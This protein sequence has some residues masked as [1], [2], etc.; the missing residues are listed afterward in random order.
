MVWYNKTFSLRYVYYDGTEL[1]TATDEDPFDGFKDCEI[2][3]FTLHPLENESSKDKRVA[4]KE[5]FI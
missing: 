2:L 3:G 1:K 4:E 5:G